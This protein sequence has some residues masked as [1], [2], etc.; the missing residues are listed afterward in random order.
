MKWFACTRIQKPA[1]KEYIKPHMSSAFSLSN[2]FLLAMPSQAGSYFGNTLTYICEHSQRGAM[3][4]MVNR[5]TNLRVVELLRQKVQTPHISEKM[6]VLEGGPVEKARGFVLH[7]NE[8]VLEESVKVTSTLSLTTSRSILD[9][10]G[11]SEGPSKYL[12][13]L[14]YSGWGPGQLEKEMEESAWLSCPANER[15]LFEVPLEE[16]LEAAAS[17]LGIDFHL[18]VPKRGE[19]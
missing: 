13:A 9:A 12:V 10:I 16:R 14:G 1:A 7:T 15:V 2:H 8:V 19:A 18:M 17:T 3:G 11:T 6:Y 4:I 5:A